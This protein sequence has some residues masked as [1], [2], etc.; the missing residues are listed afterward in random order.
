MTGK[1]NPAPYDKY[2]AKPGKAASRARDENGELDAG[3]VGSF[4]ASDPASS[5]QPAP[6]KI[7][8]QS[9]KPRKGER[10]LGHA[11]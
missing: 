3:L 7:H 1:F 9:R 10:G 4:P 5:V 8:R 6:S 2:A 11:H